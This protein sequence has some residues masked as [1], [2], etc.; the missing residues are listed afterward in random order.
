MKNNRN[1]EGEKYRAEKRLGYEVTEVER[2]C[3]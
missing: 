2:G 3:R 1:H